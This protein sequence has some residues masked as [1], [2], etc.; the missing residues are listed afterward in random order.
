MKLVPELVEFLPGP[1]QLNLLFRQL[2]LIKSMYM[3]PDV[4]KLSWESQDLVTYTLL[5]NAIKNNGQ[6]DQSATNSAEIANETTHTTI[7]LSNSSG[8]LNMKMKLPDFL[9]LENVM[10]LRKYTSSLKKYRDKPLKEA[11]SECANKRKVFLLA[12]FV[13]KISQD[14]KYLGTGQGDPAPEFRKLLDECRAEHHKG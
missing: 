8:L 14:E 1:Y 12:M 10:H 6:S 3:Y 13:L 11:I 2:S 5:Y 7:N 4:P 9:G